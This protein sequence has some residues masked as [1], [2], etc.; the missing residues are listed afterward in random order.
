MNATSHYLAT[1]SKVPPTSEWTNMVGGVGFPDV[2]TV[3]TQ[4][5]K[6]KTKNKTF[7]FIIHPFSPS[8]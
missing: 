1:A 3:G 6:K 8:T 4:V 7:I 5:R 2:A